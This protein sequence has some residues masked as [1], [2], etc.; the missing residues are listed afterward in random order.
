MD[1]GRSGLVARWRSLSPCIW[2]MSLGMRRST[3]VRVEG[4]VPAGWQIS[5]RPG[6]T[7]GRSEPPRGR[8]VMKSSTSCS[9]HRTARLPM[10]IGFGKRHSAISA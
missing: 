2:K 7:A 5:D 4:T 9:T 6:Y 3:G 10:R 1:R 8:L